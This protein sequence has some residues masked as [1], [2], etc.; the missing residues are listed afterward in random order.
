MTEYTSI[1]NFDDL[2]KLPVQTIGNHSVTYVGHHVVAISTFENSDFLQA[3]QREGLWNQWSFQSNGAPL[4]YTIDGVVASKSQYRDIVGGALQTGGHSAYNNSQQ[5][6]FDAFDEAY[7]NNKALGNWGSYGSERAW[8]EAQAPKVQGYAA[9]LKTE[10]INPNSALKLHTGDTARVD[11][12]SGEMWRQ[13]SNSLFDDKSL[14]FNSAIT[15]HFA[16]SAASQ[17]L[18]GAALYNAT[19]GSGSA[20]DISL[21]SSGADVATA[22]STQYGAHPW[23]PSV[24]DRFHI[25][26]TLGI[27]KSGRT[28]VLVLG[29]MVGGV[30]GL[31]FKQQAAMATELGRDVSFDE[32]RLTLGIDLTRDALA[33]FGGEVAA[34]LLITGVLPFAWAK[35]VWDLLLNGEDVIGVVRIY[36]QLFPENETLK[37]ANRIADA[38]ESDPRY[39]LIKQNRDELKS[40]IVSTTKSLG[41][42]AMDV[43]QLV[44]EFVNPNT[45]GTW[46]RASTSKETDDVEH[47]GSELR[48]DGRRGEGYQYRLESGDYVIK[49]IDP[50][51]GLEYRRDTVNSAFV[52]VASE[53]MESDGRVIQFY[54]GMQIV[55]RLKFDLSD[56]IVRETG[57]Q[58][59]VVY[60]EREYLP[61]GLFFRETVQ[62]QET[63]LVQRFD[64][65]SSLTRERDPSSDPSNPASWTNTVTSAP[66]NSLIDP[67]STLTWSGN[68]ALDRAEDGS[69]EMILGASKV[70]L[71]PWTGVVVF[72]RDG[73]PIVTGQPGAAVTFDTFGLKLS[74][75]WLD[76][77]RAAVNIGTDN[78]VVL[79]FEQRW[80]NDTVTALAN[81]LSLG[82]VNS[83]AA[84]GLSVDANG[85]YTFNLGSSGNVLVVNPD[86]SASL[87]NPLSQILRNWGIGQLGSVQQSAPGQFTIG[88]VVTATGAGS[89]LAQYVLNPATGELTA[90]GSNVFLAAALPA[91]WTTPSTTQ[92]SADTAALWAAINTQVGVTTLPA[93]TTP[94]NLIQAGATNW[95]TGTPQ[96]QNPVFPDPRPDAP[97]GYAFNY[98]DF[99]AATS[100]INANGVLGVA[101]N[102]MLTGNFNPWR[103][104]SQA[105]LS[106]LWQRLDADGGSVQPGTPV[107]EAVP[108][109]ME[110]VRL[111]VF[112]A[113]SNVME[114]IDPLVL[115]LDGDGIELS[116][117][118]AENIFFDTVGDGKLH[119]TGWVADKDGIVSLDLNGNGKIDDITETLS[120][121][122]NAGATPKAYA[123]GIA[124]LAALAQA[125]AT[126]FSRATSRVNATT[127]RLYFDD[128]RVWVDANHDAKTDAG[129]LK[130]LDSLGIASISLVGSGNLGE[131]IAGNDVM[132]RAVYTRTDGTTG[133]VASIDFQVEGAATTITGLAGATVIKSEGSAT[134][135][136]YLVTEATGRV[137]NVSTFTLADGTRPTGFYST[138]GNDSFLANATDTTSYWLGGGSGSLTLRGGAGNDVLLI[139]AN[140]LQAN[141]DGGGGFDIVKVNDTRGVT[142]NLAAAHVEEALGDIGSDT[143]NASGM[144]S[145]A[146]LDGGAGNDILIGGIAND[147]IGGGTG[148]DYID[149]G[150]GNDVLRG[151]GGRDLIFGGDGNDI[152]FGEGGDDTLIG[153][154]VTGADGANVLE[155]GEGN[156]LL[157]GTGAYTV[158]RFRGSYAEY[159]FTRNA[160]GTFTVTD[161][162]ADRDGTDTLKDI[163]AL[164]FAD[165]S[166]VAISASLP[167]YGYGMPANDQIDVSGP[168]PYVIS[169]ANLLANDKDF[170]GLVLSIRQ[171]LDVNGNAIARGANGRVV[172]GLAALSADGNTITFT[173]DAGFTGVMKFKYRV[174][175]SAGKTGAIVQQVG[176]TNTAEM[177]GTVYLNT[178]DQP[179]EELFNQQWYLPEVNILP[180]WKDYT[181][182]GVS[183]AVFDPSGNADLAHPDL[184]ANAGA[185]IKINGNP[186]I[187]QTGIHATLV[188]GIISAAR[189]GEGVVGVAYD[190]TISTVALPT[191]AST[192]LNNLRLWKNYDIVNNS[193]NFDPAFTDSFLRHPEYE[194]AYLDA[195]TLGRNGKGTVLVFAAGNDRGI[196]NTNDLNE[197]NSLYGITVAGINAKTDLSSLVLGPKPFSTQGETILVSAPGSNIVS[198]GELLRSSTGSVF[199][200]DYAT[201]EGTSFATPIVSGIVALM[202]EANPNLGYRDVQDILAYSAHKVNDPAT[203]WQTN[204]AKNWNGGGLHYSRDYGFGEVD[205]RAAVRLAETWQ[206]QKTVTNLTAT[207]WAGS[208]TA[209]VGNGAHVIIDSN[210]AR[211]EYSRVFPISYASS[212]AGMRVEHIEAYVDL[213]VDAY[214]LNDLKVILQPIHPSVSTLNWQGT[215]YTL[216]NYDYVDSQASVLLDGEQSVPSNAS[217]E[218]GPD[219]HR[220]LKF[221]YGSVKYRGED[222]GT[223]PWVL[224]IVRKSTGQ[225]VTP[226]AN[227]QIRFFGASTSDA[228]QWIFT[229]EYAGNAVIAPV[230]SNDSFNAAAATGNNTIDL[231][232]GTADSLINGKVVTVNGNLAKGFGGDGNDTLYGN[233]A[234]NVLDGGRGSDALIGGQGDDTYVVDSAGDVV[235]ENAGEGIDAIQS[236]ANYTLS[237]NVEN[238]TLTGA[239]SINGAGN[240]ANNIIVGNGGDNILTGFGG[241]DTINGGAGTDTAVFSGKRA[242]YAISYVAGTTPTFTIA[243]QR[244]GSPDGTD[245]IVGVEIFKFSDGSA[246][247]DS[248][249]RLA[250]W[251]VPGSDGSRTTTIYDTT[252]TQSWSSRVSAY[253]GA[254]TLRTLTENNDD[255]SRLVTQ[256]DADH[257]QPWTSYTSIFASS[258]RLATLNIVGDDGIAR[259]TNYDITDTAAWSAQTGAGGAGTQSFNIVD[260]TDLFAWSS[261]VN[262]IDSNGSLLSQAGTRDLD[263][264]LANGGHWLNAYDTA[265]V[266]SWSKYFNIYDPNGQL[267]WQSGTA[268]NGTHWLTV[269]DPANTYSWSQATVA[270]DANWN[271]MA[272]G[273]LNDDGSHVIV[274]DEFYAV[275]DTLAW[276]PSAYVPTQHPWPQGQ[277][278]GGTVAENSAA[279]TIVGI[280]AGAMG[281]DEAGNQ[282]GGTVQNFAL[283]DSAGGRFV[284]DHA[285]GVVTVAAGAQLD[286]ESAPSL[287]ITVRTTDTLGEV[288]DKTF[289]IAVS[290]VNETPTGMTMTG[291]TV[292]ENAANGTIVGTIVGIDPDAGPMFSY[293]LTDSAGGRFAV[294]ATTGAI[295]VANRTLLDYETASS[296]TITVRV[297]D[298]G[299][300]AFDKNFAIALTDVNDAPTGATMTGGTVAENSADGTAVGTVT[301]VD[302]DAGSTFTY[303]LLD[304]AGGRFG[305]NRM[306]GVVTVA[307]GAPLDYE[308]VSSHIITVRVADQGGLFFDKA[309]TISVT[310][311]NDAPTGATMT[312]GTVAENAA[313]GTVIGT[314]AGVDPDAGSAFTYAL[315]DNAG[316]RF[317]I[318]ASTGVVTVANGALLDYET[319]ASQTITARITD[320]GGL[321][322]DKT[323][324]IGLTNVN[325]AP[326]GVTLTNSSVMEHVPS[327]TAVGVLNGVDPDSGSTFTYQLIDDAGGLFRIKTDGITLETAGSW[328]A[329]EY[330]TA[331]SHTVRVKVTDQ[332]GLTYTQSL[333]I[334]I[335]PDKT[336]V[337][338]ADGSK[339]T[340]IY[341]APDFYS[342]YSFRTEADAQGRLT[343]QIGTTNGGGTWENEYDAGNTQSW[344]TRMTVTNAAHQVVSRTTVNDTNTMTLVAYDI[345]NAYSWSTFTMQYVYVPEDPN[346]PEASYGWT[347][348]STSGTN[349]NGTQTLDMNQVWNSFDTLLWYLSP[350]V[351]TQGS[352]GGEGDGLPVIL[353]LDGNGVTVSQLGVSTAMFD[354]TGSGQRVQTAWA[355]RG[356]AFLAIDVG[357]DGE[358]GPDGIIDQAKEIVFTQWAPGATSDMQALRQVFD[359]NRNGALD[360]GDA[361]WSEFRIWQDANSDGIS[362]A[363]EVGTLAQLGITS[364]GLN[365]G[366]PAQSFGD[367]SAIGGLSGYTRADGTT[368]I[369]ADV[370][371]AYRNAP[372]GVAD[373]GG[374][375]SELNQLVQA[376]AIH[377]GGDTGPI[378]LI[379]ADATMQRPPAVIAPSWQ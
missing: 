6:I 124:A 48:P 230:T 350:Y 266:F 116:S 309:F 79:T 162:H 253:D 33:N 78:A 87:I 371:L 81:Q 89:V 201:A 360:A 284:I 68:A 273:G 358:A 2:D 209:T 278:W 198:T 173:P 96:Q 337:T 234:A 355:D 214:P 233:V 363:G 291:G 340:T 193:W 159:N 314:V 180:V 9:F 131:A 375:D 328:S 114:N 332:G 149:G 56:N 204:L 200:S 59:G 47:F 207:N 36:G 15:D 29:L 333:T 60:R 5:R 16:Y 153:G 145:S 318:N 129:E 202:L 108:W 4:A 39:Q 93:N 308:T 260:T 271:M 277:L 210:G 258:G 134:V 110:T 24:F 240:A 112:G 228:Q 282:D 300:L 189:D 304:S 74:G 361:R 293:T 274:N 46:T 184:A 22:F 190:A 345:G 117:W 147:A 169:A 40:L 237:A 151:G 227:W 58:N 351:V 316:G 125:G 364:I 30:I 275:Y 77:I 256:Y 352:L 276:S 17:V 231:R 336:E 354:M 286:H 80:P 166:Q 52:R 187:E 142:L 319:A 220:H 83:V 132:N 247:Y 155:G 136:G 21:H 238:L 167:N 14:A 211:F 226:S 194:Q 264:G 249:G 206:G 105:P 140:T 296:H 165:I 298:Q 70:V 254:G 62:G 85:R 97:G 261:Y 217:Y 160:D 94:T 32:A 374:A 321:S 280:V 225:E 348:A 213:D 287:T 141:I 313:N 13:F 236:S 265:G 279:G 152:V 372:S 1:S 183:I 307:N 3:L 199:G 239:G 368:G 268:D 196:R 119:Q 137:I 66:V 104:T 172:G 150:R 7:N 8:L 126:S 269:F 272:L 252:G 330:D 106:D 92:T 179:S 54:N 325:D 262:V 283:T 88:Q 295:T 181:G 156:D 157:I 148:D 223:D 250:K 76:D 138:T 362:D 72:E 69:L 51:T 113:Y 335:T 25:H 246:E 334:A 28:D 241:A 144:T 205:A 10:L 123:D 367:G 292:A 42:L 369:A 35:R 342:W 320:Q 163:S 61:G 101:Q 305:I 161:T 263:Q 245:T 377:L 34:N 91:D 182:R 177:T 57:Y 290:N 317:A 311:A 288:L 224:R 38:I 338:H 23:E 222:P 192:N 19:P 122:F 26:N 343:Y 294:N 120:V 244:S 297:T 306:T 203:S 251:T 324:T 168:G 18:N 64:D 312:G 11:L 215:I 98:G 146:F 232:A 27:I 221:V 349:D 45:I 109:L 229:D 86:S 301:G 197:T 44:D 322:V 212:V 373:E 344:S 107:T 281:F 67:R 248:Q 219:G 208:Q 143:F 188:A 357:A 158:A 216:T 75:P 323:V 185:S 326:T 73:T 171:L 111:N 135:T 315:V 154:A 191:D 218:I 12:T 303:S 65:G 376:M 100:N 289:T 255:G 37:A 365:P 43:A 133:Q 331:T 49:W 299:G 341:D 257:V 118:I 310:N 270:F 174:Q 195:V 50:N 103:Q 121:H 84:G 347:Y 175:D 346:N 379:A 353:D 90:L 243:D 178:P 115:D 99:F 327:G 235:T 186:G 356:D 31:V 102:Y 302:Q 82:W 176:T 170:A 128:L 20:L 259:A 339:T 127:G 63:K 41:L 329:L 366:G 164:N 71:D 359:T 370:S 242:D 285:T 95:S 267:V 378:S 53:F 130:T 55:S 139:N